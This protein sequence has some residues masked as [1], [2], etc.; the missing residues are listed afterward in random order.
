MRGGG[1]PL[2]LPPPAL[3][4]GVE[5]VERERPAVSLPVLVHVGVGVEEKEMLDAYRGMSEPVGVGVGVEDREVLAVTTRV[6]ELVG[7]GVPV[8]VT[9]RVLEGV[10]VD[11]ALSGVLVGVVLPDSDGVE[12]REGEAENT[13][14]G[15]FMADTTTS[16]PEEV[17]P[18]FEINTRVREE[19][20]EV[21]LRGRL[22]VPEREVRVGE[23]AV[24][25]SRIEKMSRPASE[26]ADTTR[27]K[28]K[29]PTS[30]VSGCAQLALLM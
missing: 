13:H 8:G 29:N 23:L 12:K 14:T 10:E 21:P 19:E 16:T 4:V 30:V 3:N 7:E 9:V 1:V 2:A 20:E 24:G 18:P 26:D 25:P 11:E 28:R 6:S 5:L 22:G 17:V 27:T 15:F